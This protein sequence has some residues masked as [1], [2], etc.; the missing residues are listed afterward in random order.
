MAVPT[1]VV[2]DTDPG[3]DDALALALALRSPALDVRAIT[4][5]AGNVPLDVCTSNALRIVEAVECDPPPPVYAGC[6]ESLASPVVRAEHV[7]G[8]DGLGGVARD[9]PVASLEAEEE[10]AVDILIDLARTYGKRLT[11][12]ALGPLTN[13]ATALQRDE[14]TMSAIGSL[15]VMGGSAD[16]R[17]NATFHAEFNFYS[18]PEAARAV[19][20]SGLPVRL[21]GLNVTELA[22]LPRRRFER[23]LA[24]LE[25][26]RLRAF[27]A[28][29]AQPY[30]EFSL[31]EHGSEACS[32]HDPLA[33]ASVIDRGLLQFETMRCDVVE[34]QGLTRGKLLAGRNTDGDGPPPVSVATGVDTP[35]FVDLF[36]DTVCGS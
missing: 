33:V 7:H 18:D 24:R 16:G 17:G 36:L 21:V 25:Q 2:L 3:L 4:V 13:V 28:A 8:G 32:M 15:V 34:S 11:V 1:P 9:F 27:L 29:V 10:H 6:E 30:F 5:V 14:R 12:I 19:V 23:S 35:R 20:V 26:D 22:L 31:V